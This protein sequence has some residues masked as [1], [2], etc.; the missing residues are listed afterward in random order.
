MIRKSLTEA[1]DLF[2]KLEEE[3]GRDN[4][5]AVTIEE[6]AELQKELTKTMRGKVNEMRICEEIAD[7]L[8]CLQ[9]LALMYD[10]GNE[11]ITFYINYK[12]ERLEHFFIG[13]KNK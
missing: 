9:Q 1:N 10:P 3:H 5:L 11:H 13:G 6:C 8:I 2:R 7:V 4:Q 12:L